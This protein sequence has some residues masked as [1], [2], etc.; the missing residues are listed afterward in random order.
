M[1]KI[2]KKLRRRGVG[3]KL[4]FQVT[5]FSFFLKLLRNQVAI[6]RKSKRQSST[7][8][9]ANLFILTPFPKVDITAPP[10]RKRRRND[11]VNYLHDNDSHENRTGN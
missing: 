2:N 9:P 3:G 11:F 6:S 8:Q 7:Q 1:E 4:F 10:K 5:T